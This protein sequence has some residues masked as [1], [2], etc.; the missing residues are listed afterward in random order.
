LLNWEIVTTRVHECPGV[1]NQAGCPEHRGNSFWA[2]ETI[3][4]G[5]RYLS[6]YPFQHSAKGCRPWSATT[7]TLEEGEDEMIRIPRFQVDG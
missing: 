6:L 5:D 7:P 2:P 4:L 3:H 1:G